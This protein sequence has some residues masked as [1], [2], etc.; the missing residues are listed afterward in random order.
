[1]QPRG[2]LH[3]V[4]A[5][6]STPGALR[7]AA[8]AVKDAG[9][10]HWDCYSP[11]PV[12]GIDPD[13]GIRPTRLPLIVFAAGLIG[14]GGGILLQWWANAF[15]WPWIVSGKPIWSIPANIPIAFETTIL[16]A[17]FATFFGMW[18]LNKLPEPYYPLFENERFRKVT[19]DGFFLAIEA[20][21]RH[22]DIKDTE[23]LLRDAGATHV[24]SCFIPADPEAKRFP[25]PLLAFMI[26]TGVA[27]VIPVA[28]LAKAR[29]EHSTQ[30]R[31][32]V[33]PDMDFQPKAKSQQASPLFDDGRVMRVAPEGTVARGE[34]RAD[35][36]LYKGTVG[37]GWTTEIP[38]A[39]EINDSTL[40]R[41]RE[42]YDVYCAPCHGSAG[43]GDGMVTKRAE[44]IGSPKWVT[45]SSLH[46]EYIVR[47]P[48]GQ[49]FSTISN[50]ARSMRGYAAQIDVEDRWAIVLYVRA[51]QRS[52]AATVDDVPA[53]KRAQLR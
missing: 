37:N 32:H 20:E 26:M 9:Y 17:A 19:T 18:I 48:H 51:L 39:I 5:E 12:H 1:M 24:E 53:D 34:L 38:S 33:I 3:G 16:L 14:C 40:A 2:Q 46:Q 44:S 49:L 52:Q 10:K 30:P 36:A 50:G 22:F 7:K 41:G 31:L 35:D 47:M 13:M 8:R 4:L 27:A 42:R 25:R 23:A 6:F 15:D 43:Y 45:P 11:F 29:N 21:D 28:Y